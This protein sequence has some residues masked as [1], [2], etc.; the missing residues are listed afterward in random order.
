[1]DREQIL[2]L[3]G[4]VRRGT[5]R[6]RQAMEQLSALSTGDLGFARIDH[7]RSLRRGMPEVVF[8][9]GKT[10]DQLIGIVAHIAERRSTVLVTR[11][12]PDVGRELQGRHPGS[13]WNE[14]ARAFVLPRP[15]RPSRPVPGFLVVSAGTAD[16]P[17]AEEAAVCAEAMGLSAERL[18]DVG[19]AGIHRLLEQSERLRQ[20]RVIAVVA[21]MEGA[22]PSVVAGL[23]DVPVIGVPTSVGYGAALGGF[24]ALFG[25]LTSCAGGMTVVNID[26]GFGAA[27]AARLILPHRAK[28]VPR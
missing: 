17:V 22:L 2:E 18:Y 1:V 16:L 19:V 5:V 8:G 24:T 6:P 15:G 10:R 25:M 21:G 4:R 20:A 26:N 13:T 7:Q 12:D 3:L 28:P 23:V 9:G 27:C 11:L 14:L